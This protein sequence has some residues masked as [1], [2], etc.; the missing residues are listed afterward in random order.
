MKIPSIVLVT[1]FYDLGDDLGFGESIP[2]F[3]A[4]NE[5]NKMDLYY[6]P[7]HYVYFHDVLYHVFQRK[8]RKFQLD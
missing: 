1:C 2:R 3:D 8:F 7:D 5:I 6:D 4:A